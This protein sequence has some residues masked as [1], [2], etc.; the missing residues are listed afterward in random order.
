MKLSKNVLLTALACL[1]SISGVA[2]TSIPESKVHEHRHLQDSPFITDLVLYNAD[3]D[4]PIKVLEGDDIIVLSNYPGSRA[5]GLNIVAKTTTDALLID[6]A[7][8][9]TKTMVREKSAPFALW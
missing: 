4:E 3:S 9:G 8:V 6:F 1:T 2:A 5:N 7:I